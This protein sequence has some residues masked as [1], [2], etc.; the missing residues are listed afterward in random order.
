MLYISGVNKTK[1]L[2]A[3]TD[4]DDNTTEWVSGPELFNIVRTTRLKIAGVELNKM[5][6]R[7]AP[8]PEVEVPKQ[9]RLQFLDEQV[10][11]DYVIEQHEGRD[12]TQFVIS[13]GGDVCRYRV[14]GQPGNYSVY[15]K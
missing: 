6:I 14:Y 8:S 10:G 4:T 9:T 11:F 15:A 7:V 12:F 1:E 5:R 13:V 3:V 2:Y